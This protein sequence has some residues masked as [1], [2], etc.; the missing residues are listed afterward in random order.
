MKRGIHASRAERLA[1]LMAGHNFPLTDSQNFLESAQPIIANAFQLYGLHCWRF[2]ANE[3]CSTSPSQ[4]HKKVRATP[5]R[6][7]RPVYSL[8]VSARFV[9]ES[10]HAGPLQAFSCGAFGAS[11]RES[12]KSAPSGWNLGYSETKH[13]AVTWGCVHTPHAQKPSQQRE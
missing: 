11:A 10:G 9:A 1:V 4:A 7:T 12:V 8:G 3:G 13:F 5:D 6:E 2:G